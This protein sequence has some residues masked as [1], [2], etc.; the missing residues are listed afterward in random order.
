MPRSQAAECLYCCSGRTSYARSKDGFTGKTRD[1]LRRRERPA[2]QRHPRQQ[3]VHE[4]RIDECLR[5]PAGAGPDPA[6]QDVPRPLR[7]RK[8]GGSALAASVAEEVAQTRDGRDGSPTWSRSSCITLRRHPLDACQRAASL[9]TARQWACDCYTMFVDV[10]SGV[11]RLLTR[12]AGME[13]IHYDARR[14]RTGSF[15]PPTFTNDWSR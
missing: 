6:L 5:G 10:D 12:A 11:Y 4:A 9:R 7:L 14:P 8:N 1:G 3:G 2:D 15:F 13:T